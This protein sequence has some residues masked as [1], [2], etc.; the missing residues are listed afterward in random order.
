MARS[1][2]RNFDRER[3]IALREKSGLSR[4]E[5]ATQAKVARNTIFQWETGVAQPTIAP[6]VAA[7]SVLRAT[8][9]DVIDFDSGH[10]PTLTDLRMM[11]GLTRRDIYETLGLSRSGW[12]DIERGLTRMSEDKIAPVAQLLGVNEKAVRAAAAATRG[13]GQDPHFS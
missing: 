1:N 4:T 8:P 11:C 2:V 5:L 7:L 9:A 3:F 6:L 13:I 10:P 12:S